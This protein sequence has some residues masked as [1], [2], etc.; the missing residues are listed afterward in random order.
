M[1]IWWLSSDRLQT[2]TGTFPLVG[3]LLG[4]ASLRPCLCCH[5]D[6]GHRGERLRSE[7]C[8]TLSTGTSDGGGVGRGWTL[9]ERDV[10]SSPFT[11]ATPEP[12]STRRKPFDLRHCCLRILVSDV[13][14]R[15]LSTLFYVFQRKTPTL[16]WFASPGR[17]YRP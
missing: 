6:D 16:T 8:G 9:I 14:K 3:A 5:D 10:S 4:F 15:L 13:V 11:T 1:E 7:L 17:P 12:H 2:R